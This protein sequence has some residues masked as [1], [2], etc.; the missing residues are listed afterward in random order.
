M[1]DLSQLMKAPGAGLEAEDDFDDH[2]IRNHGV[3]RQMTY[4]ERSSQGRDSHRPPPEVRSC[5]TFRVQ[6]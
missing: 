3:L 5:S 4:G 2:F 6:D 1:S